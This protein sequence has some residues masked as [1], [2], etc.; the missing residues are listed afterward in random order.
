MRWFAGIGTGLSGTEDTEEF[1][2]STAE[3]NQR[4]FSA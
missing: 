4:I 3:T 1:L 2:Q